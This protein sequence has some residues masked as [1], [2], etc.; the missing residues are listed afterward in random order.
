MK[1]SYYKH[2]LKFKIPSG[3]SRGVLTEKETYILEIT[4]ENQKGVGECAIFRGLSSDDVPDYEEKLKFL[5]QNINQEHSFIFENLKKY[6]SII[7]GY[8]QAMKNLV[9]QKD[10]YFQNEFTEGRDFIKINGLIWMGDENSMKKQIDDKLAQNFSC[11]KIKIGVDWEMEKKIIQMIRKNYDK[12]IL[13]IRVDA[14]GAFSVDEVDFV[15][16][17]LKKNDIHSI[18]QPIKKNQHLAMKKICENSPLPIVLDEELIGINDNEEKRELLDLI[19]P[20]YIIL[21]PALVGGFS[22]SDEWINW[23]E[24]KK[25]GWWITSALE[26]NIGLNAIAQY[27]YSKKVKIPQGLGTGA[28]FENNF[29][30]SLKLEGDKLWKI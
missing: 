2:F 26:S 25:I 1:A 14:N 17:D 19:N 7:F 23:A 29:P 24:Q 16:E 4:K 11:I 18:E 8:E 10:V 12:E 28:L 22:G 6:P 21:K 9:Y 15:L 5:C 20:H 27:T 30:S 13:E 3:T